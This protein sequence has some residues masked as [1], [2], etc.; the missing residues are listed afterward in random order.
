MHIRIVT[1]T[2]KKTTKKYGTKSIGNL[3][4]NLKYLCNTL[5]GSK[6]GTQ[7]QR[8]QGTQKPRRKM[9]YINTII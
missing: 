4:R 9:T 2:T 1:A 5:G 3:N 8:R 6:G 7:E